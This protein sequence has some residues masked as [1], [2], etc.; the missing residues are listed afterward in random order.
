M[1]LEC[2][3]GF[4][5]Y[6]DDCGPEFHDETTPKARKPH[7]C[8]ECRRTIAPGEVYERVVG[9]WYGTMQVYK[10]CA[11]CAE[12]RRELCLG[13]WVYTTLWEDIHEQVFPEFITKCLDSLSPP[14]KQK[15]ID[16]VD[17]W[18]EANA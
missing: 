9:K 17:D 12:I 4:D 18:M 7:T 10:T 2:T 13:N 14:A 3:C 11:E 1:S 16:E 5:S 8:C 15:L 6:T